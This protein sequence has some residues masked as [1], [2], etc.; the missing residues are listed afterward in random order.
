VAQEY[1]LKRQTLHQSLRY[2]DRFL[3]K[4]PGVRKTQLQLLGVAC[5]F[6]AAKFEETW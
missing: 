3:S 2:V 5:L 4:C 6:V 1:G